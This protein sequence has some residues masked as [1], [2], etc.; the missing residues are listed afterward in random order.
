MR[1]QRKLLNKE[2]LIIAALLSAIVSA[3]YTCPDLGHS[4]NHSFCRQ[5]SLAGVPG[6]LIAAVVSMVLL[7]G[8]HGGG[9][10]AMLLII[11][12][13]INFLLYLGLAIAGRAVW[14][15]LKKRSDDATRLQ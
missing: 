9:P 4:L 15:R 2:I 6:I 11:A 10:L 8:A 3:A 7:G 13:P 5:I 12:T 1:D 14:N